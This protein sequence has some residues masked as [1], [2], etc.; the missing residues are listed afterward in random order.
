MISNSNLLRNK[1]MVINLPALVISKVVKKVALDL[2]DP[3]KI[4]T[5]TELTTEEAIKTEVSTTISLTIKIKTKASVHEITST[6]RTNLTTTTKETG[7][8]QIININEDHGS[9]KEILMKI[10]ATPSNSNR[11]TSRLHKVSPFKL[12]AG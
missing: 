10:I 2:K 9:I 8:D 6:N 7:T 12:M 11:K 3:I 5:L 4:T 1:R